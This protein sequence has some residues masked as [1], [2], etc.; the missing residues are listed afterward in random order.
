MDLPTLAGL[1]ATWLG[2]IVLYLA[3]PNQN[4]L[5]VTLSG[6][7]SG[8]GGGL[9]FALGLMCLL[10]TMGGLA[11][12]FFFATTVMT[13]FLLLPYVGGLAGAGRRR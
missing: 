2:C 13:G 10:R 4:W 5:K 6:K 8:M 11:A 12:G 1:A 3:S 7:W 9:L